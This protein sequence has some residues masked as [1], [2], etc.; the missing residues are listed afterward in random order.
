MDVDKLTGLASVSVSEGT[1]IGVV[2]GA[3]FDPATLRVTALAVKGTGGRFVIPF[4]RVTAFGADAV[5]IASSAVTQI[6]GGD[7]TS[8][9]VALDSLQKR[10]VVDAAGTLLGILQRVDIDPP[11]GALGSI[12]VHKGGMLG[13][14][15]E[16]TTIPAAAIATVGH[17]LITITAAPA[18][19]R[20]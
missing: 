12:A 8:A 4:D 18:A 9:E 16:T 5:T 2:D 20:Q 19:A 1:K 3:L 7:G 17:D 13:L 10:K 6:P 15:G 14:G 11:S